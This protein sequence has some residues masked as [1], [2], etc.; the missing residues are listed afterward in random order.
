MGN[1]D[2]KARTKEYALAVIRRISIRLYGK[3][4][5]AQKGDRRIK[6]YPHY[7]RQKDQIYAQK[8]KA[9]IS[10]TLSFVLFV[11]FLCP[12][13]F[14]PLPLSLILHP[15]LHLSFIPLPF[16]FNRWSFHGSGEQ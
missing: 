12:F 7:H 14:I 5:R 4:G 2:L 6:R 11:F 16:A 10:H 9:L 3:V 1:S 15:V 13:S 8:P